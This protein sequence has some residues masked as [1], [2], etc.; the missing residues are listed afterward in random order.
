MKAWTWQVEFSLIGGALIFLGVLIPAV[1]LQYRRYGRLSG[2][3]LLG[4]LAVSVY[5]VALVAYVFLPLPDPATVCRNGDIPF[6]PIPFEF[7]SDISRVADRV[8]WR[9]ALTSTT[10]LQVVFNVVLF[11]PFGIIVRR[12]LGASVLVTT[13]A[14]FVCSAFIEFTQWSAIWGLY[15]CNYRYGEVDDLITNTS[16]ALIGALI[17]PTLLFWMPQARDLARERGTARPVSVGRRWAGMILD[18]VSYVAVGLLIVTVATGALSLAA[19]EIVEP[20]TWVGVAAAVVSGLVVFFVPALRRSGASI[21]QSIVWLR[22]TWPAATVAR[23]LARAGATGGVFT[24][25]QVAGSLSASP[26]AEWLQLACWAWLAICA[27]AVPFT[28]AARGRPGLSGLISGASMV[29]VRV[30]AAPVQVD[31]AGGPDGPARLVG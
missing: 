24:V 17:A 31:R 27:L 7:V 18:L 28:T 15:P 14:G 19:G 30:G 20:P 9:R 12:Y 3:R 29:D 22:P 26:V 21:G 6:R 2:P 8:G 23:R 11:I 5:V 1:V 4:L 10:T 25:G 16:G 13:V